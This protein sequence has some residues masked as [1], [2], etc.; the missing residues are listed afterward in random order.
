MAKQRE[1]QAEVIGLDG[2]P[3][4]PAIARQKAA[5]AGLRIRFDHGLATALPYDAGTFDRVL[6]SLMLHHLSPEEKRLALHE[7][8]R[9]LRSGGEFH[10][11]DVIVELMPDKAGEFEFQCQMGMLRGKLIVE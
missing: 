11:L 9:V 2:D 5:G 4:V 8:W 10:I 6:A 1:P 7:V 3:K